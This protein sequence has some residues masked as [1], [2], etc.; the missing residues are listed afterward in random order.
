MKELNVNKVALSFGFFLGG[1]H[2]VWSVLVALNFAQPLINFILGLHMLSVPVQVLPFSIT[3]SALLIVV[4]FI[5]GYIGGRI[6]ATIW[7]KVHK[8]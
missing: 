5:V 7:N 6:F 2:L 3:T 8:S 4:T 1:W